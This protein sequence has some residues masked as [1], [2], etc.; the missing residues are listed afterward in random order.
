V[1][2]IIELVLRLAGLVEAEGRTARENLVRIAVG[3]LV[4]A[5]AAA[6][7]VLALIAAGFAIVLGLCEVMHPGWAVTIAACAFVLIGVGL[8]EWGRRSLRI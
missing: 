4:L 8:A 2:T 3:L 7:L 5:T 1:R 6:V